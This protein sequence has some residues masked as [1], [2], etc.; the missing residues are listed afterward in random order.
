MQGANVRPLVLLDLLQ[1]VVVEDHAPLRPALLM[2]VVARRVVVPSARDPGGLI[3]RPKNV[4]S[5]K[6]KRARN[7]TG[8]GTVR[9]LTNCQS[10]AT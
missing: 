4:S 5:S 1:L 9:I 8:Y 3:L 10:T 2:T 6:E 7:P